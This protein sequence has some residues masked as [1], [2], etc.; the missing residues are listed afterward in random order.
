MAETK[1]IY[2]SVPIPLY[3]TLDGESTRQG[4]TLAA[5]IRMILNDWVEKKGLDGNRTENI[6]SQQS[7]N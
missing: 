7:G 4:Q 2:F 6:V 1:D 3:E 5:L